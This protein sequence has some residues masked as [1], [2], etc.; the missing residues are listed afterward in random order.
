MANPIINNS[1]RMMVNDRRK[2]SWCSH[3]ARLMTV[4]LIMTWLW[5]MTTLKDTQPDANSPMRGENCRH[6]ILMPLHSSNLE[7]AQSLQ[8][9]WEWRWRGFMWPI[10][11]EH[12]RHR[13][14][15]SFFNCKPLFVILK[16]P[17]GLI[18][19]FL[20][21]NLL[22]PLHF[23]YPRRQVR[24]YHVISRVRETG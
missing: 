10:I 16:Y 12:K 21:C 5:S 3:A 11:E 1:K 2:A 8:W 14:A 23:V 6:F 20:D 17:R 19:A 24:S 15:G 18:S 22:C 13:R 9:C 7:L 4:P